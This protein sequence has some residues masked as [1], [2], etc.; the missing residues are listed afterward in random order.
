MRE[1][2]SRKT[3]KIFMDVFKEWGETCLL[4]LM[5]HCRTRQSSSEHLR[6][7][8]A[9]VCLGPDSGGLDRTSFIFL[10]Y[11]NSKKHQA[12]GPG[13]QVRGPDAQSEGLPSCLRSESSGGPQGLRVARC[14][15]TLGISFWS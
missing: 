3:C 8:V 1:R 15:Q 6:N 5:V 13:V 9:D 2:L 10:G 4:Q 7:N 12:L 14:S 11:L